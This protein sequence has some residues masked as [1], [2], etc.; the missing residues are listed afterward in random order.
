MLLRDLLAPEP[1]HVVGLDATV[2]QV[3]RQ[4]L[5][6]D[7]GL[8]PVVDDNRLVGVVTDRDIVLRCVAQEKEEETL[9]VRDVMS[10]DVVCGFEDQTVEEVKEL[11]AQYGVRRLPVVDREHKVLGVLSRERLEGKEEPQEKPV[12]V[13]M[14]REKTDSYGR[15]HKVPLKT[16]YVSGRKSDEDAK[17]TA[18][19]FVQQKENIPVAEIV[20]EI[21]V[22]K[23]P[24]PD[25]TE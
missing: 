6:H 23:V 14:Y 17:K 25:K 22:E 9:S 10:L 12:K 11:M 21:D 2:I 16:V 13:T 15:P 3:A 19:E 8:I 20:D 1:V 18:T 7:L 24:P 5:K 4:M